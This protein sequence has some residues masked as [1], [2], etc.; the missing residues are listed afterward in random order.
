MNGSGWVLKKIQGMELR[1]NRYYDL[2]RGRTYV[3]V[4]FSTKHVVNVNNGESGDC[5]RYAMLGKFVPKEAQNKYHPE[6]YVDIRNH[7]DF[8]VVRFPTSI[9]DIIKFEKRNNVSVSVFGL[10]ESLVSNKNKYTV[11]PIQVADPEREDHTDLLSLSTPQPFSYHY[12]WIKNFEQ[13][14]RKQLTKHHGQI[15]ICKKCFTYKYSMEQLNQHKVL[16]SLVSKDAFLAS[17]PDERYLKFKNHHK[18]IK[19]N[20]VIYADFEAYL[21]QLY[22]DSEHPVS[23]YRRHISNSYAYLL[24]KEDPEFK[25]TEPKLYRV[26]EAH[27]KFLDDIIT[28]VGRISESYNDKEGKIIMTHEDRASFE[29]ENR[30]GRCEVDFSQPG[31]VKVRDHDHQK[32]A[33]GKTGSNYR[34]AL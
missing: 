23:A 4:P 11:Y 1:V 27:I 8:S 2:H 14:V 22:G 18:E 10:H 31:I 24:N 7:Y 26:E 19:H 17:F 20:Y 29:A 5:F 16:C 28:L 12:C 21:E 34:K 9:D 25:M 30:C 13:L 15:Y 33:G 6:K 3:K 32:R